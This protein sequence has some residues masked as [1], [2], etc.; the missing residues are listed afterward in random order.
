MATA[1][2]AIPVIDIVGF[3]ITTFSKYR[4]RLVDNCHQQL[5]GAGFGVPTQVAFCP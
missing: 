5:L 3:F 1:V 2:F 4:A